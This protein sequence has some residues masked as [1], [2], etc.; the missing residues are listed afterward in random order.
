MK[1]D[2]FSCSPCSNP[3]LGLNEVLDAYSKM[4]YHHFEA[5]TSWAKSAFDYHSDPDIYLDKMKQYGINFHSLHLPAVSA[6]NYEESLQEAIKCARFAVAI[7][8][9]VVLYK[10]S[11]RPTY[12]K[13]APEFLDAIEDFEI[14]PVIQNH[15]GT[16]ISTLEDFCEV[17]QGINDDRMKSLLEVGHFFNAGV[18]WQ[19]GYELLQDS[20]ALIHIKD[21]VGKQSVPFGTGEIDLPELFSHMEKIGYKGNYVI[22]MEVADKENTLKYLQEAI[23][24]VKQYCS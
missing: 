14:T 11:D 19:Q 9:N 5:F 10:A 23:D 6:D 4:G 18:V 2:Q 15:F 3:D 16:P 20:I 8:V 13:A 1:I 12:I 21:Q 17:R 22:E 7:G 24:Y